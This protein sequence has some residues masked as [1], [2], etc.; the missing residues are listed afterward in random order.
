MKRLGDEFERVAE[1]LVASDKDGREDRL[2]MSTA[3]GADAAL[4]SLTDESGCDGV[5]FA[6]LFVLRLIRA[7]KFHC[8]ANQ[9]ERE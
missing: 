4:E 5:R 1:E 2:V 6:A 7:D 8:R 3:I 9:T